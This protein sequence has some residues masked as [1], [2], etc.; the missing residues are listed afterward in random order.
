MQNLIEKLLTGLLLFLAVTACK[1]PVN[2]LPSPEEYDPSK[3]TLEAP[4]GFVLDKTES[5]ALT[6]KWET[7]TQ[8]GVLYDLQLFKG[9]VEE[10]KALE[11]KFLSRGVDNWTFNNLEAGTLYVARIRTKSTG[12]NPSAWV[13][14]SGTTG[15]EPLKWIIKVMS[16]NI[17]MITSET[18]PTNNW[19]NRKVAIPAMIADKKPL[20]MGLQEAVATQISYLNTN[21]K[22]YASYGLG[23]DK[24][25]GS[26]GERMSIYYNKRELTMGDHGT[27]WLSQTP[28]QCS[29][30]W[31]AACRRTATWAVFTHNASGKKFVH[32]NTHLDHKGETAR[33]EGLKLI[34]QKMS[35]INPD[36]LPC[37]LTGDFNVG[38]SDAC[39]TP[40]EAYMT[41]ARISAPTSDN[42][43]TYN[44]WGSSGKIIDYIWYKG[45]DGILS[46]SVVKD[47][48]N[49][50]PFISDHYPIMAEIYLND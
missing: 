49:N 15:A 25:D 28:D 5:N 50:V 7:S 2:D 48:Y 45:F 40:L 26:A 17:R 13:E 41:N 10:G 4:K 3:P 14:A 42:S 27:F 21:L 1:K 20:I 6:F 19:D 36:N 8:T 43:G 29:Y 16:F 18:D 32:V 35:T 9:G 23:R 30:G 39:L 31:D 47:K 24:Q 38:P 46:Y 33:V 37:I 44:G 34:I 12:S 22:D 11:E